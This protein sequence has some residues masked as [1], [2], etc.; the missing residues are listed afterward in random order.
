M[1]IK[2]IH[3]YL[4]VAMTQVD[5]H[6]QGASTVKI[7]WRSPNYYYGFRSDLL[8]TNFRNGNVFLQFL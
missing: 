4:G 1:E 8:K 6:R 7:W 3:I 2:N 5:G